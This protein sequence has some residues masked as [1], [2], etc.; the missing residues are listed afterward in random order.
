MS[1]LPAPEPS[2]LLDTVA[3]LAVRKLRMEIQHLRLPTGVEGN[4][5]CIRHPGASL[6]VPVLADGRVVVKS[7]QENSVKELQDEIL[8]LRARK[9]GATTALNTSRRGD[10]ESYG[11]IERFAQEAMGVARALKLALE[12]RTKAP[13]HLDHPVV[14]WMVRYAG[15]LITR[16]RIRADGVTAYTKLKGYNPIKP[17]VEFG[18][19]IWFKPLKVGNSDSKSE[20]RWADGIWLGTLLRTNENTIAARNGLVYRA[21]AIKRKPGGER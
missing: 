18:E 20:D 5:G 10:S 7:D 3:T 15:E 4:Y 13:I 14:P 9:H 2:E 17:I 8:R 19:A 16:F 11:R 1:P 12:E 6:A 21:G